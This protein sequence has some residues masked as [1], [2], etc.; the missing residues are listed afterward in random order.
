MRRVKF[1]VMVVLAALAFGRAEAVGV[2]VEQIRNYFTT[3]GCGCPNIESDK[4]KQDI[5]RLK[6]TIEGFDESEMGDDLANFLDLLKK[7]GEADGTANIE[8]QLAGVEMQV[9]NAAVTANQMIENM[10]NE[11]RAR[12]TEEGGLT[13]SETVARFDYFSR[14]VGVELYYRMVSMEIVSK[15]T[16]PPYDIEFGASAEYDQK[17]G[18]P[19]DE[20]SCKKKADY[21][22]DQIKNL[23]SMATLLGENLS[24][25]C[26]IERRRHVGVS[27]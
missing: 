27:R 1:W 10:T 3:G 6:P 5:N 9:Q 7:I 25:D 22:L 8:D 16:N 21:L 23:L 2:T 26:P 20:E 12:D 4:V 11:N 19:N 13:P 15:C 17:F 24:E 14:K 18:K